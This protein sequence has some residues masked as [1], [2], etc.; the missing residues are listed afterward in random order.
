[1]ATNEASAFARFLD[2]LSPSTVG[3]HS[4]KL[5]RIR[6]MG[7]ANVYNCIVLDY[8]V[9]GIHVKNT[10]V[11]TPNQDDTQFYLWHRIDRIER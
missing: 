1:M 10:Q 11:N 4:G 6:L 2:T 8:D 5:V 3:K 7:E 9:V